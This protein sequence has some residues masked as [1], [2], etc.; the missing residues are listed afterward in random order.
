MRDKIYIIIIIIII[1]TKSS[2]KKEERI[3]RIRICDYCIVS[4][5]LIAN[6]LL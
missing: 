5:D 3:G 4:Y 6:Y 1:G 2:L